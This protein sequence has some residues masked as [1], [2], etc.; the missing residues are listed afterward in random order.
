MPGVGVGS[1]ATP[2][3]LLVLPAGHARR[4]YWRGPTD[5]VHVH[6][7]PGLVARA[8]AE[9]FDLDPDRVEIPAVGPLS[10]SDL[11][12]A[13]LAFDAEL[14]NGGAGGRLLAESLGNVLAVHLIRHFAAHRAAQRPRGGL[15]GRKL[16][17][18]HEYIE[19]HLDSGLTLDDLAAVAHLNP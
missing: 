16:R 3:L 6:L 10:H 2:G 15:S 12:S 19:E 7:D 13:H 17:A 8:A 11:R 18:V 4:A 9:A 14:R 1:G 5:S